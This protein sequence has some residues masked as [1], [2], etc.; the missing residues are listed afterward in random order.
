[1]PKVAAVISAFNPPADLPAKV[2][3]LAEAVDLVVVVDDGS[4]KDPSTVLDGVRAAGAEVVELGTNSG[5]AA[6]LNAG[7][8]CAAA[9]INPNWFITLDQDSELDE[10]FVPAALATA[11]AARAA[12]VDLGFV[13][14]ESHNNVPVLLR[15]PDTAFPEC[16]D[17]M[18]SGSVIP[19]S[20]FER[21]GLLDEALFIDA[22][23]S[24]FTA[25]VRQHGMR[26]VIGRGCNITH[27]VG[28]AR[29]M[30]FLG[31]HVRIPGKKMYVYYHAP[32]RVYYIARNSI[33]LTKRYFLSGPRWILKR[34][35]IECVSHAVRFLY[36][37]HRRQHLIAF[38]YGTRDGL[39]GRFGKMDPR[40][41][42]KIKVQ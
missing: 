11:D 35:S 15:D 42:E 30:K 20:T 9:R 2:A 34:L 3:R 39:L 6:A 1:M 16:F 28:E 27:T 4:S 40:I 25:R 24:D 7:I 32:F 23:D 12:G 33:A 22:V 17:P 29:P 36:G 21:V 10:G 8:R 13:C 37:P 41:A 14:P 19:A 26:T 31:W 18:Q 38:L 5:I